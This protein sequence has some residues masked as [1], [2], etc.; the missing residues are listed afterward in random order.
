MRRE[1][2][3]QQIAALEQT[4]QDH[5]DLLAIRDKQLMTRIGRSKA[6][7][8]IAWLAGLLEGEGHF[9]MD[10][11]GGYAYPSVE[12]NMADLD[13][14]ERA[15]QIMHDIGHGQAQ[16]KQRTAR[17]PPG[18]LT[19]WRIVVN[20][21]AAELVM[22]AILPYMGERRSQRIKEILEERR[23]GRAVRTVKPKGRERYLPKSLRP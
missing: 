16:L 4:V 3:Y 15:T 5:L 20:G 13:I 7:R 2:L 17:Q 12:L 6:Q 1:K 10:A 9:R 8:E 23:R 11:R 18:R 14:V 22:L 21:V 19:Q